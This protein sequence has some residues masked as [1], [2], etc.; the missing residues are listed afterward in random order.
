MACPAKDFHYQLLNCLDRDILKEI[1][2]RFLFRDVNVKRS[3]F[4]VRL[5]IVEIKLAN[6]LWFSNAIYKQKTAA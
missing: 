6:V 2:Q 5:F 4:P 3:A 1:K